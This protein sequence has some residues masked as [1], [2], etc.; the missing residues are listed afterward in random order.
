MESNLLQLKKKPLFE[1]PN[2]NWMVF[3]FQFKSMAIEQ[4]VKSKRV[5]NFK[6]KWDTIIWTNCFR[7]KTIRCNW[8]IAL[9]ELSSINI[10]SGQSVLP[11]Q[12]SKLLHVIPKWF[13]SV[14]NNTITFWISDNDYWTWFVTY[15]SYVNIQSIIRYLSVLM[16]LYFFWCLEF[17]FNKKRTISLLNFVRNYLLYSLVVLINFSRLEFFGITY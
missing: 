11:F 6:P 9:F 16:I 10:T 13:L 17:F 14:A 7:L 2:W 5:I 1:I 8:L 15:T 4:F 12:P 3:R